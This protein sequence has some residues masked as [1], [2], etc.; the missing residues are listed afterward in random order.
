M[1]GPGRKHDLSWTL[2]EGNPEGDLHER[3]YVKGET[4]RTAWDVRK[5]V[6]LPQSD[7]DQGAVK[8]PPARSEGTQNK[9]ALQ[10]KR[11]GARSTG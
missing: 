5:E 8:I 11:G 3:N 2:R 9:K 6:T 7:E 1:V 10:R 4:E